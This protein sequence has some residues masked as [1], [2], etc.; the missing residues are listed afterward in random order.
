MSEDLSKRHGLTRRMRDM[1]GLMSS[2]GL[3]QGAAVVALPLLQRF[4]YGPVAFADMAVYTQLAGIL[5]A[6][7][8]LRMDL[9]L[10]KHPEPSVARATFDNGLRALL[11]TT[12]ISL[13]IA[14][15]L[16]LSGS[17]MGQIQWL[18]CAL[19]LGVLGVGLNGLI[20]GWLTRAERFG[21]MAA[22]RAGGG[23]TGEALRFAAAPMG[24]IGLIAGRIAG[25]WCT[26]VWGL[27]A[28]AEAW[29]QA[30]KSTKASRRAA[31]KQD[32]PYSWYTTPANLLAMAANGLFILFLFEFGEGQFVGVVGAGMAY[33][34]VAAG[35]VIRSVNDVFFKH[36]DD[37]PS[38]RLL[39]H[40]A[41]WSLGLIA[42]STMGIAVL[43]GIPDAWVTQVLGSAWKDM[44]PIMRIL[45]PWMVPWI[46][47]SSLSGI[48]PH[49]GRQS[50][51]LALDTL[52][53]MMVGGLLWSVRV[54]M[55]G[56]T[57]D[58]SGALQLVREYTL[59][60][61][62]FYAMAIG[63]AFIAIAQAHR[64]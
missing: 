55:S 1:L 3:A 20:S 34:T 60:Q 8:T 40:Y 10:V 33:L 63:V 7:A 29:S 11:V 22:M 59:V 53:L 46:A 6:V 58:Q 15:L 26:V 42:L 43:W 57:L 48:F 24:S 45:A 51:T 50:W 12:G 37:I 25:Q 19:P 18:W 54:A 4:C 2:A 52:H 39:R 27:R 32:R 64:H 35:L 36:L 9:A 28:M 21:T 13:V 56:A 17:E 31:W 44:L 14:L 38:H 41:G 16:P 5:G 23:V 49:L 47:A 30:P 61:G 62:V